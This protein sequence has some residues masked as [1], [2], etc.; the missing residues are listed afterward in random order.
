MINLDIVEK[1]LMVEYAKVM[2][3]AEFMQNSIINI[4]SKILE[5]ASSEKEITLA[6]KEIGDLEKKK[7]ELING[8]NKC[9]T[10]PGSK[11]ANTKP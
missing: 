5:Q 3:Q 9:Q 8:G 6:K 10:I 11:N 7:R 2:L 1:E 4:K